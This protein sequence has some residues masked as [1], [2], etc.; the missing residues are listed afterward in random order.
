MYTG[1]LLLF[2]TG[3]PQ[4]SFVNKAPIFANKLKFV[5]KF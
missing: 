2:N 4:K 5:A 1:N 3:H